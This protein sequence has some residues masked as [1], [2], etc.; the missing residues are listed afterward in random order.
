MKFFSDKIL[1]MGAILFTLIVVPSIIISVHEYRNLSKDEAVIDNAYTNQLEALLFSLNQYN[2]DIVT[3]WVNEYEKAFR[4]P[5]EQQKSELESFFWKSK[6][7]MV[8]YYNYLNSPDSSFTLSASSQAGKLTNIMHSYGNDNP[9]EI[10]RLSGFLKKNYRQVVG[11]D[12]TFGG[13]AYTIFLF[14]LQTNRN[15]PVLGGL[16]IESDKYIREI[17]SPKIQ[18][19]AEDKVIIAVTEAWNGRLVY[20]N[21]PIDDKLLKKS[22]NL[23]LMPRHLMSIQLVGSTI[24]ELGKRRV[25]AIIVVLV[26]FNF[27][28]IASMTY[29]Y[30]NIKRE[31][32]LSKIK[33]DF[34]SNVSHEIRTPLA[35]I[36]MYAETLLMGRIKT[37]DKK[38]EYYHIIFQETKR[39]TSIVN[40]ILNFSRIENN[41]RTYSF[42][43]GDIHELIDNLVYTYK[44]ILDTQGFSLHVAKDESIAPL[45]MD[46]EAINDALVNLLSN[47]IKYSEEEKTIEI[48]TRQDNQNIYVDISDRGIGIP[49]KEQEHIFD[50]F[51]RVTHGN[52]AHHAQ[53]TGLGLSI[54]KHIMDAHEGR[55]EVHSRLGHGS[56]FTLCIPKNR[57]TQKTPTSS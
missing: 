14:L 3:N 56:T 16:A 45:S 57:Y 31:R 52:L 39:L 46:S 34:V 40:N 53:G 50:K 44:N 54:V 20:A 12:T 25:R 7:F 37:E 13:S 33:S 47:A 29:L 38:G 9:Q 24:E 6:N 32:E 27:I 1:I 19:I 55:I 21:Q 18:E 41:R 11:I 4:L 35:M 30:A 48:I 36:S 22:K 8:L 23:W 42:H 26:L 15:E 2:T 17:L 51:Y 28:I 43:L 10:E 5:V 49:L